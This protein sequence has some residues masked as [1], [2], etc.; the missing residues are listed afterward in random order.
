[1]SKNSLSTNQELLKGEYLLS[2][3]GNYKAI[4]QEDGNF[5]IYGWKPIWATA[6]NGKNPSR[7]ILQGDLNLVMYT[8]DNKPVWSSGTCD[9]LS[10]HVMRL[11]LNNNGQLIVTNDG[12]QIWN[13][14]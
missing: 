5:V 9:P 4:F 1:M 10:F 6:T 2:E 8:Q 13:S 7:I 11:T 14:H 3:N 12:K